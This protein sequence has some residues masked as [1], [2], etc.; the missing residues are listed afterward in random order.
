MEAVPR[1]GLLSAAWSVERVVAPAEEF[2]ARD[3]PQ[4]RTA[5]RVEIPEPAAVL[6]SRQ[7]ESLLDAAACARLGFR[8][9]RRRSGGGLVILR[10]GEHVWID[11]VVGRDDQWWSDDVSRSSWWLG[12]VWR[13]TVES[14][15]VAGA[16]VHRGPLVADE[17]GRQV[18]FASVGPGEVVDGSGAKVV[19]ISQRRAGGLARFQCTVFLL[20]SPE[21]HDSLLAAPPT[22][23]VEGR[24]RCIDRPADDVVAVF[25]DALNRA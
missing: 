10:P 12:E 14:L 2:H 23:T 3:L 4:G 7:D 19:G 8:I 24:V 9:V 6:G 20:W 16:V 22:G 21:T 15:G 5:W 13:R 17:W 18:C 25:L 11:L 1:R